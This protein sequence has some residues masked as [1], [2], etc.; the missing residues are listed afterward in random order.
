[1]SHTVGIRQVQKQKT[2]QALL[3]AALAL[4]EEQS[5]SSLGLRE[6]TRAVGV[7]P[8]AFYR[9]FR[10]TADLGVALVDEA[11]GSLHRMVRSTV[12][13]ADSS[14]ERIHRAVELIARHVDAYPAHV[15]FIAR[16]RHGGVQ[17]VREAIRGQLGRFAEEVRAE[18]AKDPEARG[19]SEDDLLM[20]SHLYVDQMLA[21]ASLFLEA[22]DGPEGE[23]ERIT[24]LATRQMRLISKGRRH[25]LD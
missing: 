8:T 19:W 10:S 1:M 11:L 7:A 18:L 3:D 20:L 14:D 23:R 21:T 17:S 12:T 24:R 4:L 5:L 2:R 9:H 22:L 16:E 13:T 6:V 25:W 15:R